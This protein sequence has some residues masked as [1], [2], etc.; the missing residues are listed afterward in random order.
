MKNIYDY[1]EEYGD[2][3]IVK[4]NS[5]DALIFSRLSYV[6]IE[7]LW[8]MLP[9]TISDLNNYI[10]GIGKIKI[11]SKDKKLV[12]LLSKK[13]RFKDLVILGCKNIFN[14]TEGIQFFAMTIELPDNTL[15]IAFRG[16]DKSMIGLME[17]VDMSYKIVP[18]Q[19]CALS[20]VLDTKGYKKIYLGGHSKGGNLAVYAFI[21]A[22][23]TK[24]LQIKKV[25]NFDGP[26][27]LETEN[28][29][30]SSR[31]N[32][33]YPE[34][35][36]IG[37]MLNGI[38]KVNVIK[39]YK[40]GLEGHNLYN[41]AVDKDKFIKGS[42][43]AY[44]DEFDVSCKR[45]LNT[46]KLEKREIIIHYIYDLMEKRKINLKEFDIKKIKN[47]LSKSPVINKEEKEELISFLKVLI[48][49]SFI[50]IAKIGEKNKING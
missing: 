7:D 13:K 42:F 49:V 48:K 37:R 43:N 24:K 23:I 19:V 16:T 18:S 44:S 26:G 20:Y 32:N 17:D 28:N 29:S 14:K 38:G 35:S 41:W 25:Y 6:H 30:L 50:E 45:L 8:N 11:S 3:N 2:D 4:I 34:G 1:I 15:F 27:F 21:N 9:F 47:L 10:K 36:F 33:Y 40:N 5:L 46:I 12:E 39:S 31:I 22:K